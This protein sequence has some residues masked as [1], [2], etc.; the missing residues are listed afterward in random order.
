MMSP[1]GA[2]PQSGVTLDPQASIGNVHASTPAAIT[3]KQLFDAFFADN[4]AGR[5]ELAGWIQSGQITDDLLCS[6]SPYSK[7]PLAVYL[8]NNFKSLYK[9]EIYA[10]LDKMPKSELESRHP[11]T[12]ETPL[13]L[14]AKNDE[15][16]MLFKLAER[17]ANPNELDKKGRNALMLSIESGSG[18][19]E[20]IRHL[21]ANGLHLNAVDKEGCT[22][23]HYAAQKD[24]YQAIAP[25]IAAGADRTIK[26]HNRETAA[27]IAAKYAEIDKDDPRENAY[28]LLTA[29]RGDL[30]AYISAL[31]G[32][33]FLSDLLRASTLAW[34]AISD[35][36]SY[37]MGGQT[38]A[39]SLRAYTG[40]VANPETPTG[41][42]PG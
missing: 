28:A 16:A 40:E 6:I 34:Q 32:N 1:L 38:E 42:N 10:L 26:N 19:P 3:P 20:V 7:E 41:H 24:V 22:A 37:A 27:D 9:D 5:A 39:A 21:C 12:G 4:E 17:G 13:I 31:F 15:Q 36:M 23:L 35:T 2:T 33:I 18:D 29:P 14:A 11:K 8:S 30:M 25:L